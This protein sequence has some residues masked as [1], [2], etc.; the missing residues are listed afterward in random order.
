[1][2]FKNNQNIEFKITPEVYGLGKIK[3][4]ATNNNPDV[5]M[6]IIKI[7]RNNSSNICNENEFDCIVCPESLINKN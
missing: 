2:N 3:G 4:V 1:M 6:W 7:D 5:V